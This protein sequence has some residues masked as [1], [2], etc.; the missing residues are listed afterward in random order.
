[1]PYL[2]LIAKPL[3]FDISLMF[4][5]LP[6]TKQL[7]LNIIHPYSLCVMHLFVTSSHCKICQLL[8][9]SNIYSNYS[10]ESTLTALG[11]VQTEFV[12]TNYFWT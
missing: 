7:Q 10:T 8:S 9:F 11:R 1:M 12:E 6:I 3:Q 5:L 2:F 4:Y